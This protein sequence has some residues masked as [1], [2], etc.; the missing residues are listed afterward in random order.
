RK[1][2]GADKYETEAFE[3]LRKM[4][5]DRMELEPVVP[6]RNLLEDQ[7]VWG[8]SSVRL[9]LAG[10]W[11]DTP[12]FCI[13]YG[14]RVVNVAVD[15]NGQPP[16]QVFGRLSQKHEIVIRSIDLGIEERI[17]SYDDLRRWGVL[18]SGFGIAKAALALAGFDP[19]FQSK[20]TSRSL[21]DQ[22]RRDF[23]G[24]IELS[25]VCAIP[26][27]SG[28]GTSSILAASLLGTLSEMCGLGWSTEDLFGRT[29]ALE[30]MLTAGGGWQDQVGGVTGG[31][32][33]IE[34]AP[35]LMQKPVMRWLPNHFFSEA[36]ANKQILLYYT[37]MTRVAHGI[38]GEIVRGMFL[39]SARHLGIIEEIGHNALF[40]A[41]A[42]QRNDWNG[43]CESIRRS[44]DLNQRLDGG[45]NPPQV[46]GILDSIGD[47]VSAA[48]LLGAGGGGYLLL[49]AKDLG[50]ASQI[51][52][53]LTGNPPNGR[54]RFVDLGLSSKGFQVTRS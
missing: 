50:S 53:I 12:P 40:A 20:G 16:I 6:K 11:S 47:H 33:F 8:R 49:F 15:L 13:E 43:L 17:G 29:L 52:S 54:A 19:Q 37:G 42:I 38:L 1:E 14:G 26:K 25:M 51:R 48:K 30:Q 41:D 39:N 18:G 31:V 23:G 3:L 45:T 21:E 32:K 27:G 22:L 24:G 44:W 5:V 28:L 9:D 4:I 34:T 36:Y 7:V 10:G 35:G 46:K 2:S